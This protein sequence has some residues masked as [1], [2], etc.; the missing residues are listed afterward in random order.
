MPGVVTGGRWAAATVLS[1]PLQG[2]EQR[3]CGCLQCSVTGVMPGCVPGL[4]RGSIW[5]QVSPVWCRLWASS[6]A[7][8]SLERCTFCLLVW[9]GC[10]ES[11]V[12]CASTTLHVDN[13]RPGARLQSDCVA[14]TCLGY[15]RVA[16]AYHQATRKTPFFPC[17]PVPYLTSCCPQETEVFSVE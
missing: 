16:L 6:T 4:G 3:T 1:D 15:P 12:S 8:G 11:H 13:C 17:S 7:S 10:L 2:M 9:V 5:C 14:L